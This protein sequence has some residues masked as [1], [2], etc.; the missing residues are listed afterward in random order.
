MSD[1]K[2]AFD[3]IIASRDA[4]IKAEAYYD[5]SQPEV[6]QSQRWN[7]VFRFENADFRFNFAKTV[8]DCV[9]NRL[10]IKQVQAVEQS[11]NNYLNTVFDQT[12]IRLD[13]NEIHRAA[14]VYG[15]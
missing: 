4:Y 8:V 14:L 10:D 3:H 11:A 12:D 6:F 5:G 7:R 2:K 1:I 15:D 9:H 13:M